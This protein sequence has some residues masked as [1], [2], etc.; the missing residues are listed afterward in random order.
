[1]Y[2]CPKCKCRLN[3][4]EVAKSIY[5]AKRNGEEHTYLVCHN[6]CI[7]FKVEVNN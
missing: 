7:I 4:M 1:M 2:R 3:D 5:E 6:C